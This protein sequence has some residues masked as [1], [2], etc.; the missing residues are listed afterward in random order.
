MSKHSKPWI[1]A[2]KGANSSNLPLSQYVK[3]F[4]R[5]L[6]ASA[7]GGIDPWKGSHC[8][9]S[10][11]FSN[12]TLVNVRVLA[13]RIRLKDKLVRLTKDPSVNALFRVDTIPEECS[14]PLTDRLFRLDKSRFLNGKDI[15]VSL[16]V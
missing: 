8:S 5:R 3:D 4:S 7:R 11:D 15:V 13:K 14:F 6:S 16:F 1:E 2:N 9:M 10:K 12:G